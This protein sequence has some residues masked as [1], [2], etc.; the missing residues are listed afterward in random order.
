MANDTLRLLILGAHPD[1]AEFHAG[2]LAAIYRGLGHEVRMISLTNGAAG[3]HRRS[4]EE[5]VDLRR[6]EAAAAGAIIGATYLT[7]DHPDGELLPTL[8]LRRQVIREIRTFQPDLLLTHRTCDYHPD[9]RA[10]GQVVQDASFMVIVPHIVPDVPALRTDAVVAYMPDAF[11]KPT[12]L[13]GDVVIDVGEQIET[14]VDMLCCHRS[15]V[16]EWLPYTRGIEDQVPEDESERRAWVRIGIWIAPDRS[17]IVIASNSSPRMASRGESKSNTPKSTRSANTQ[18][19]WTKQL[20]SD[21]FHFCPST[22]SS[23]RILVGCRKVVVRSAALR[24]DRGA[25]ND[26]HGRECQK[27]TPHQVG[28]Q[29]VEAD[30]ASRFRLGSTSPGEAL[31]GTTRALVRTTQSPA[32][33]R[34]VGQ[35]TGNL[36][37]RP[38]R[39]SR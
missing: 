22:T 26:S 7:W 23:L 30:S 9:H 5:L 19:R 18:R 12:P 28:R 39:R 25:I 38:L 1:D 16:F 21:C 11:T 8:D 27:Q 2:G 3:H 34:R 6:A 32:I 29:H 15:Q 35:L 17:P 10:V 31:R 24:H 37:P 13:A 14:V 33:H 36:G 4:P 20:A